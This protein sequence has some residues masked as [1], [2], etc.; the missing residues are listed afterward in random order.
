MAEEKEFDPFYNVRIGG[1]KESRL[2]R[3]ALMGEYNSVKP[4]YWI[5]VIQNEGDELISDDAY[6]T[7][8]K[9]Y[10]EIL[11]LYR[12]LNQDTNE[13]RLFTLVGF[14][15]PGVPE[16]VVQ[17]NSEGVSVDGIIAQI[18]LTKKWF[19]E[20]YRDPNLSFL[21]SLTPT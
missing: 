13:P 12:P 4:I 1:P 16:T 14:A 18:E 15:K 11:K 5:R 21:E 10:G 19:A 17:E 9:P 7:L 8:F 2:F 20:L 3:V 6:R